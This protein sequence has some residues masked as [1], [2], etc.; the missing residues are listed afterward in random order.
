MNR[1][2]AICVI[3]FSILTFSCQPVA[4][5]G[6]SGGNDNGAGSGGD[7]PAPDPPPLFETQ[8]PAFVLSVTSDRGTGIVGTT[9][10]ISADIATDAAEETSFSWTIND[11]E[12]FS[13]E[14]SP[15]I[16]F[17]E[18]GDYLVDV[19]V[20]DDQGNEVTDGILLKVFDVNAQAT[21]SRQISPDAGMPSTFVQIKSPILDD[22]EAIVQVMV[23]DGAPFEPFRPD[24][25]IANFLIPIDAAD[26]LNETTVIQIKLLAEGQQQ[27]SFEFT[28]SPA[29][30]L[31]NPPGAL[32]N[33]LLQSVPNLIVEAEVS[34]VGFLTSEE[35]ELLLEEQ[36]LLQAL[37]RFT[38]ARYGQ[39]QEA[40]GPIID[41]LSDA[42][43]TLIDQALIAN[44]VTEA[45]LNEFM[46]LSK[47]VN[48]AKNMNDELIDDLC[49]FHDVVDRLKAAVEALKVAGEF[50]NFYGLLTAGTPAGPATIAASNIIS[51]LSQALKNLTILADLVPRVLDDLKVT[52][53]PN[54]LQDENEKAVVR[55][56][57]QLTKTDLCSRANTAKDL[58][59]YLADEFVKFLTQDLLNRV[60]SKALARE[61]YRHTYRLG[62]TDSGAAA[63]AISQFNMFLAGIVSNIVQTT[64]DVTVL[65]SLFQPILVKLCAVRDRDTLELQPEEMILTLS[66][67]NG[68]MFLN[69][70][71]KSIDFFCDF[72]QAGPVT[73]KAERECGLSRFGQSKARILT[74][75]TTIT[76]GLESCTEDASNSIFVEVIPT[77]LFDIPNSS[78]ANIKDKLRRQDATIS[79]KNLDTRRTVK[80]AA[81]L[82]RESKS[83]IQDIPRG[84]CE[85]SNLFPGE[86]VADCVN[87]VGAGCEHPFSGQTVGFS[88]F[89]RPE[90][91]SVSVPFIC[92]QEFIFIPPQSDGTCG[93]AILETVTENWV[94]QAVFCDNDENADNFCSQ[95]DPQMKMFGLPGNKGQW[96]SKE[97]KGCP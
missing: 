61:A 56:K 41:G 18:P 51:E 81:V 63:Q 38:Q 36:A 32:F 54:V 71:D 6:D 89:L 47:R 26:S 21:T 80:I 96:P 53:M 22:P 15:A 39:V 52:A 87:R 90:E 13:S 4:P 78:C 82:Y 45:D 58:T 75:E 92:S 62:R 59:K 35:V 76:C 11:G 83:K 46:L 33:D 69:L 24:L 72:G 44:G 40:L 42:D 37:L 23:G 12:P 5:P 57:A 8:V 1:L 9:F 70:Q 50:L 29:A 95:V 7:S 28:L 65:D 19:T 74:G 94:I 17:D 48:A 30:A 77:T 97:R 73:V 49:R 20:Q 64:F 3:A 10:N 2:A 60:T 86:K 31:T 68:G 55:V 91:T 88:A 16:T 84:P 67:S 79:V 85:G 66:P 27:D 25:G 14:Q 34:L 93:S 43:K